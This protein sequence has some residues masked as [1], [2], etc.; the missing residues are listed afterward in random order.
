LIEKFSSE[1]SSFLA[2]IKAQTIDAFVT[3]LNVY[4]I[5]IDA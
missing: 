2:W 5:F 1:L 3:S 4:V